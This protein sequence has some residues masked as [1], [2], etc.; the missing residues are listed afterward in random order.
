[1]AC[2]LVPAT[3]AIVTTIATKVLEKKEKNL[4]EKQKKDDCIMQTHKVRLSDKLKKLNYMLW[5][6]TALLAFEHIWHGEIQPFF[7]FLT[8]AGNPK[9]AAEM[10]HEMSTV[11]ISMAVVVTVVWGIMTAVTSKMEKREEKEILSGERVV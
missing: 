3:E 10:I 8:A 2:L 6:G 1:M 5:G 4:D 7:P 11:G 9:D